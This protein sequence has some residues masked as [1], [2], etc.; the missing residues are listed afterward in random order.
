M[1]R[2]LLSGLVGV[3][4]L[5]GA[6]SANA[7]LFSSADYDFNGAA[8]AISGLPGGA[9]PACFTVAIDLSTVLG[10]SRITTGLAGMVAGD[11]VAVNEMIVDG[12]I[13]LE[14]GIFAGLD[15]SRTYNNE[16]AFSGNLTTTLTSLNVLASVPSV[17]DNTT[18]SFSG[19]MSVVYNG[20]FNNYPFL[21]ISGAGAGAMNIGFVF[22]A[23]SDVLALSITESGLVGWTGF[24]QAIAQLDFNNNSIADA[25]ENG[26]VIGGTVYLGQSVVPAGQAFRSDGDFTVQGVPEPASLA[27]LGLGIAGLGFMRR[28]KA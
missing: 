25:Q 17:I 19:S 6:A 10:N 20:V 24:E 1:N 2:K 21:N 5:G 18:G 13:G 14:N 23:A 11:S 22:N 16:L 27:L 28:R 12:V 9:N 26:G 15:F 4:M 3:A 8:M 7:F